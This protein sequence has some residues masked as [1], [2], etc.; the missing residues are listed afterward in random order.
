MIW[1]HLVDIQLA[2]DNGAAGILWSLMAPTNVVNAMRQLTIIGHALKEGKNQRVTTL[3]GM[4]EEAVG[5]VVKEVVGAV[6]V[7]VE[8]V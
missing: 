1:M 6:G 7:V 8:T 3:V 4:L 2:W 5:V